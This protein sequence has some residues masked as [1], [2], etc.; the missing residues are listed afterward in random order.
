MLNQSTVEHFDVKLDTIEE[1]LK[2]LIGEHDLPLEGQVG[3]VELK[4]VSTADD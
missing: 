3:R 2:R 1:G 4:H